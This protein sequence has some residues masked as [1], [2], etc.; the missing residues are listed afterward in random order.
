MYSETFRPNFLEDV[1]GHHEAKESLRKYLTSPKFKGSILLSGPPGIGKTTLALCAART[2]G[3]DPLEINASRNI[4]SFEDVEKIKDACRSAVN[5]HSL[6]LNQPNRKTCI[7]L[8]EV[9]GSDPHAQNKI[10]D[11]IKDLS[12]KV[13]ILCTGNELPTIFKRNSE[14]I[15]LIRCFPPRS[16]DLQVL[17][18][19][20]DISTILK[21]CQHDVRRVMHRLQYGESYTIPKFNAPPTGLAIETAF[22]MRQKMFDLPDPLLEYHGDK[23][24]IEHSSQTNSK[25]MPDG[26][27]VYKKRDAHH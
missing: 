12:R 13:P 24:G 27:R 20:T 9:D 4:R 11:W 6:L 19:N 25:Y 16:I 21:E 14:H 3:F 22:V 10:V 15:E 2:F 23:Q 18:K 1:I 7:I 17:F 26:K 5:I 8:D